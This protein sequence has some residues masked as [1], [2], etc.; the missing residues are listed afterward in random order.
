[1]LWI[2]IYSVRRMWLADFTFSIN[3]QL[4]NIQT[5]INANKAVIS[6]SFVPFLFH[7]S[8]HFAAFLAK[9]WIEFDAS[10]S[11]RISAYGIHNN[12][13]ITHS[14]FHIFIFFFLS[15][16][17]VIK[18][19]TNNW[20]L[21]H[22]TGIE[23]ERKKNNQIKQKYLIHNNKDNE[24][25]HELNKIDNIMVLVMNAK[26]QCAKYDVWSQ[27]GVHKFAQ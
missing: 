20:L 14:T 6:L 25:V 2:T 18:R 7:Y 3:T 4:K 15:P 24:Y 9:P 10:Y 16:K 19:V 17:M 23:L 12:T 13:T 1:M 27:Q 11:F 26:L 5:N 8:H 21:N 22:S